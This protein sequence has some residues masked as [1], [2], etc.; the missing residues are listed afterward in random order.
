MDGGVPAL[1]GEAALKTLL[2]GVPAGYSPAAALV[3]E[4]CA[5]PA[6]DGQSA[7]PPTRPVDGWPLSGWPAGEF[8]ATPETRRLDAGF[9]MV[10]TLK[11]WVTPRPSDGKDVSAFDSNDLDAMLVWTKLLASNFPG[12]DKEL[13]AIYADVL[14]ATS[15]KLLCVTTW[16]AW[17]EPLEGLFGS[18]PPRGEAACATDTGRL[19]SLFHVLALAPVQ[20]LPNALPPHQTVD[21]IA[22]FIS[23]FF[24]CDHCRA[25]ALEQY[26]GGA[27]G[28]NKLM[29]AE[30]V[31][32]YWWRFHNAVSVRIAAEGAC[33]GDRRWPSADLC[34]ECWTKSEASWDVLDEAKDIFADSK[35]GNMSTRGALPNETE[36]LKFLRSTYWPMQ[37]DEASGKHTPSPG[38]DTA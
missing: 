38:Q 31:P 30:G 18:S 33:D 22:T 16:R 8:N 15:K 25:H 20:G 2:R 32:I 37:H 14:N 4:A 5:G 36:V 7:C 23:K 17:L 10:Y 28:K 21:G 3:E 12:A 6:P 27:Y 19:W 1:H 34:P 9:M 26:G 29:S 13:S 24:R 35:G 11:N